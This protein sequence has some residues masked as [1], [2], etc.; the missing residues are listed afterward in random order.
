MLIYW[1]LL[2]LA[3]FGASKLHDYILNYKNDYDCVQV[4]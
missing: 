4:D 2:S 3:F 1:S